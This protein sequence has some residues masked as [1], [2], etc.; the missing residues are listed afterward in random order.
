[1]K[2]KE[3]IYTGKDIL[4]KLNYVI[5]TIIKHKTQESISKLE[6]L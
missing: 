3:K 2:K 1:M 5:E 4:E 6:I